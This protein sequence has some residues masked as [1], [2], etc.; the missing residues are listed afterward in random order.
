MVQTPTSANLFAAFT[1]CLFSN[2]VWKAADQQAPPAIPASI[3]FGWEV[4]NYI[5]VPVMA[6]G[7]PAS[8]ELVD[9]IRCQC[10][11]EGKKCSTVS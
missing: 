8:P 9:V 2:H 1:A 6:T 7:E 5:P 3:N 4:Q 11:E 10:R